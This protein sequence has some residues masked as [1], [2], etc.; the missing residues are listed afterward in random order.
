MLNYV[1]LILT[2][3][4][5]GECQ[6]GNGGSLALIVNLEARSTQNGYKK[7]IR[8]LKELNFRNH[9]RVNESNGEVLQ[10]GINLIETP[11]CFKIDI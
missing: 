6:D 1:T 4:E 9:Q 5:N 11:Y 10:V 7:N 3:R 8:I 2:F